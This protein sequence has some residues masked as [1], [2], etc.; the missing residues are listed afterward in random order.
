M[1]SEKVKDPPLR[2]LQK[3]FDPKCKQK[4]N[5]DSCEG[6]VGC[7]WCVRDKYDAPLRNNY[8]A[9]INSCYG[10]KEGEHQKIAFLCAIVS[11]H[12]TGSELS[13][14]SQMC[15]EKIVHEFKTGMKYLFTSPFWAFWYTQ[16]RTAILKITWQKNLVTRR[17]IF[18]W[19]SLLKWK[20]FC[21]KEIQNEAHVSLREPF[22]RFLAWINWSLLITF[23]AG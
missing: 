4:V 21:G 5:S 23:G 15:F 8:C 13:R 17:W 12:L 16:W 18:D 1:S 10:G 9:D 2:G 7:Y 22:F 3:C 11:W 6:V 20:Q 19:T 14:L